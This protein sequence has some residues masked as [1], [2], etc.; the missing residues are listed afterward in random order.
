VNALHAVLVCFPPAG[1]RVSVAHVG[2]SRCMLGDNGRAV[3]LT[4]DHKASDPEEIKRVVRV[5]ASLILSVMM[6][7]SM[8]APSECCMQQQRG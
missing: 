3:A 5:S 8:R 4:R 6:A 1:D 2:D 7:S